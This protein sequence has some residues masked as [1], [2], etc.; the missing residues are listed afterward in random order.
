MLDP[1][2]LAADQVFEQLIAVEPGSVL[3]EL[4]HPGKDPIGRSLDGDGPG[5][6]VI[7]EA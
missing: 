3:A 1:G 5:F 2:H 7:R 4:C 6:V